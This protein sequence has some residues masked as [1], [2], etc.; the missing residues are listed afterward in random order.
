MDSA[1]KSALLVVAGFVVGCQLGCH[2]LSGIV[3]LVII[4]VAVHHSGVH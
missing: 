4:G 2:F 3:V 1:L